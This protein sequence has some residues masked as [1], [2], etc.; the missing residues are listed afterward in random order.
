MV[1]T[2]GPV[3]ASK[4]KETYF[5]PTWEFKTMKV[6]L[7]LGLLFLFTQ[8]AH[9]ETQGMTYEEVVSCADLS[10]KMDGVLKEIQ[11]RQGLKMVKNATPPPKAVRI[12]DLYSQFNG[13]VPV[14]VEQ[15]TQTPVMTK[16]LSMV[17]TEPS[18]AKSTFCK[19]M[20]K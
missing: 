17:C 6:Y 15:C 3:F 16:N 18:Y 4:P 8:T 2:R 9:A 19:V 10:L 14:F 7:T 5:V 20:S 12:S 1:K 13:Y 11:L